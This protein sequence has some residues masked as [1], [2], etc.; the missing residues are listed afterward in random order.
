MI[1]LSQYLHIGPVKIKIK[2]KSMDAWKELVFG[3]EEPRL[4]HYEEF[5]ESELRS[6]HRKANDKTVQN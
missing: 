4:L 6:A 1:P 5:E 2:I 3:F